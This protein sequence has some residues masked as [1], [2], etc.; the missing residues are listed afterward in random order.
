MENS[1]ILDSCV[2]ISFFSFKDSNHEKAKKVI[3]NIEGA[4][5]VPEIVFG[6]VVTIMR[7]RKQEDAIKKFSALCFES[8]ML[9]PTD[10]LLWRTAVRYP[11]APKK[12]SFVD[13]SLYILSRE[14]EVI[15]FDKA[16]K[17]AVE[18]RS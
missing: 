8:S 5:L 2:W 11:D 3:G 12:L 18:M 16:L 6:E 13:T 4:V 1:V 14:Y 10:R 15:T 17:K 9:L 7:Q